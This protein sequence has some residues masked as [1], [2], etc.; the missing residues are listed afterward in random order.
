[1]TRAAACGSTVPAGRGGGVLVRDASLALQDTATYGP[2]EGL[3][4]PRFLVVAEIGGQGRLGAKVALSLE[5]APA[6]AP[7]PGMVSALESVTLGGEIGGLRCLRGK[8]VSIPMLWGADGTLGDAQRL[9]LQDGLFLD[10]LTQFEIVHLGGQPYA[11]IGGSGNG[12]IAVVA[13][14]AGGG[15]QVTDLVGDDQQTRFAGVTVLESI[16]VGGQVYV[17]AGGSAD[18]LSL[19]A[20]LPGGRFLHLETLA[21]STDMALGNPAAVSLVADGTGIDI[22]VA[23]AWPEGPE[24]AGDGITRLRADLG[25]IGTVQGPNTATRSLTGGAGRDQIHGGA[26]YD[27][28]VGGAGDDVLSGARCPISSCSAPV[29]AATRNF[30]STSTT[31]TDFEQLMLEYINR[32]RLDPQGEFDAMILDADAGLAV[33]A[34]ITNAIGYFGVD[35]ELF[36]AQLAEFDPVAPLAWNGALADAAVGHSQAMIDYAAANPD[37][38]AQSHQLPE[39]LSPGARKTEAGY[40]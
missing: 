22:F 4:A 23:G 34:N 1:M 40:S 19:M 9:D 24:G 13:L 12:A 5:G 30:M 3:D 18:G 36:A 39:G 16:T 2:S 11:L 10:T 28:I 6:Q 26:G 38:N 35:L 25:A 27:T 20:L 14:G 17:V 31:P 8:I 33:Q 7:G 37:L 21:D 15:M 32:A 29:T